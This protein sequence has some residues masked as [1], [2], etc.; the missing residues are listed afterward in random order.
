[1]PSSLTSFAQFDRLL[2]ATRAEVA[3]IFLAEPDDG[4]IISVQ[5]Q[6]EALHRWTRDGRCPSQAEKDQLNFGQI[7]S[8]A[9]DNYP[10]ADSLY[11]LA[12]FVIYWQEPPDAP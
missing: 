1:M 7:A 8:R 2:D 11:E 3:R 12:S 4:A 9:L 5:R 6:L 10:V